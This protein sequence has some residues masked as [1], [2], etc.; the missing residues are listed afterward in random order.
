MKTISFLLFFLLAHTAFSQENASKATNVACGDS[1]TKLLHMLVMEADAL[2]E[3][4]KYQLALEKY[5]RYY[6]CHKANAHV[7]DRIRDLQ[8]VLY[9][10]TSGC[11]DLEYQLEKMRDYAWKH[12]QLG[13]CGKALE[14]Y[15]RMKR[16]SPGNEEATS[17]YEEITEKIRPDTADLRV[18]CEPKPLEPLDKSVDSTIFA[19]G[20][21]V[22]ASSCRIGIV[23]KA[24]RLYEEGNYRKALDSYERCLVLV[25]SDAH[26][27]NRIADIRKKP[28]MVDVNVL[29]F[30]FPHVLPVPVNI[31]LK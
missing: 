7:N 28:G 25:S 13:N 17:C 10:R 31:H 9:E 23:E 12:Y 29:Q 11:Y 1:I 16:L 22:N 14:F 15:R 27:Q 18:C 21:L 5:N 26:V 30:P 6:E 20:R 8:K 4:G 24:D 2:Y 3:R 19:L